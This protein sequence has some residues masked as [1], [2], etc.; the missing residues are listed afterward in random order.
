ME[1]NTLRWKDIDGWDAYSISS[2]EGIYEDGGDDAFIPHYFY[3]YE[4]SGYG[5]FDLP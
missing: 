5:G 1:A 4:N 3:N 2:N